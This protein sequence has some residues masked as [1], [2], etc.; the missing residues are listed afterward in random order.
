MEQTSNRFNQL[1]RSWN[2]VFNII[3]IILCVICIIPIILVYAI[4]FTSESSLAAKGYQ[5]WP[6]EWSLAAYGY[7][8]RNSDQILQ[9]AYVTIGVTVIGT[10]FSLIVTALFAYVLSRRDFRYRN[11]MAFF[12]FFTMLF[13]GGLV[14]SYIV[15]T[16]V[17]HLGDS[18]WILILPY[19]L[20]AFNVIILRTFMQQ[21]IET[22]ILEAAR[23]DGAGEW[24]IFARIVV[25][26]S[27]P[28]L[29]TVGL[30]TL[31]TYW[32]DW[33][34]GQLYITNPKLVSLQYML[35]KLQS[36][37][38]FVTNNATSATNNMLMAQI[39]AEGA[40]MAILVIVLTPILCAYPFFQK[41]FVK[42]LT[43]GGIKG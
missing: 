25:P 15:N 18:F 40:R 24:Y 2:L 34:L 6:S 42:G 27:K 4:S 10:L 8:F 13:N 5:F 31:V 37:I 43:I 12:L 28:G 39:P 3:L 41:Y 7:I 35:M 9:S 29:A 14:P 17:L 20:S 38:D 11:I 16:N 19:S 30:F 33:F 1:P 23:I 26:L 36:N 32:N 22:A 21:S